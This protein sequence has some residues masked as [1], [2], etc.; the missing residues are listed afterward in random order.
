[1]W[2]IVFLNET[3]LAEFRALPVS[4]RAKFD[5]IE[6]LIRSCGLENLDRP[7]VAHVTDKLWE[8]RIMTRDSNARCLY[9]TRVGRRIV[10]LRIFD[11]KSDRI[12]RREIGIALERLARDSGGE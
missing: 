6:E 11:K 9:V 8:I 4:A 1:M 10:L 12:P 3:V 2:E 5:R 7:Y